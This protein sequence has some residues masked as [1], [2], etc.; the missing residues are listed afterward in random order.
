MQEIFT[1]CLLNPKICIYSGQ[2]LTR[3]CRNRDEFG[4]SCVFNHSNR[5]RNNAGV[6]TFRLA[7]LRGL[8]RFERFRS[9]PNSPWDQEHARAG[10]PLAA[11]SF[12]TADRPQFHVMPATASRQSLPAHEIWIGLS[13][14][15]SSASGMFAIR[16][17][18]PSI[19]LPRARRARISDFLTSEK[20]ESCIF[21]I[22]RMIQKSYKVFIL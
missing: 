11:I 22:Y 4:S 10:I 17:N 15:F 6:R 5:C 8:W 1:I 13:K 16:S 12:A 2:F 7:R 20:L 19:R 3:T 21:Q 9:K 18:E 14:F